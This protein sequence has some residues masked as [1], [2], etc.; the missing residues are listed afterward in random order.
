M[1]NRRETL[2]RLRASIDSNDGFI[3]GH[4]IICTA[5]ATRNAER[6]ENVPSWALNDS[7]IAEYVKLRYPKAQTD[8]GQRKQAARAVRLIHLYYRLG[9]S[10]D[11]VAEQLQ[12]SPN[13]V[14]M[15]LQRL[16]KQMSAPLKRPGRPRKNPDPIATASVDRHVVG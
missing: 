11:A 12:T 10:R 14:K 7:K 2:S 6:M 15:M 1:T 8:P 16:G 5:G 4:Q 13:A 3:G 9:L